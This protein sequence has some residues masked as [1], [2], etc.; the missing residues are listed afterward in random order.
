[1][2]GLKPSARRT[3]SSASSL[4]Q[5][6]PPAGVEGNNG[7][8]NGRSSGA[9]SP[10]PGLM[11]SLYG[12]LPQVVRELLPFGPS[13]QVEEDGPPKDA[14]RDVASWQDV[15]FIHAIP[16]EDE[17]EGLVVLGDG[18]RPNANCWP[19]NSPPW[20]TP[21]IQTFRSSSPRATSPSTNI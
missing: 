9:S 19:D 15:C 18:T 3:P 8:G 1:M 10:P 7:G 21:A 6:T 16:G 5:A 4:R 13:H 14:K 20:Q 17:D 12:A 11:N 2:T